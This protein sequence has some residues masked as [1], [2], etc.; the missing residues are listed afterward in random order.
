ML[1]L[2]ACTAHYATWPPQARRM[3]DSRETYSIDMAGQDPDRA[4]LL[5]YDA[6][7]R[8]CPDGF[9]VL[10]DG[11]DSHRGAL[12]GYYLIRCGGGTP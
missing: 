6:A 1:L 12:R 5:L 10:E 8:V 2:T 9:S 4:Q 3:G 11:V 7:L